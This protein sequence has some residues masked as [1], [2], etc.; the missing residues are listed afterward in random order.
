MKILITAPENENH[1]APLK[2]ALEQAGYSVACWAG[3]GWTDAK[4]ASISLL[5][6]LQIKDLQIEDAQIKAT[7][8]K[9]GPHL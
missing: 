9:L 6:D 1:T 7:Q 5:P 3:L 2:W 8:L 4:Q